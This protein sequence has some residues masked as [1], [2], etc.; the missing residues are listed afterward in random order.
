MSDESR[1]ADVRGVDVTLVC[2][3]DGNGHF[4]GRVAGAI[5]KVGERAIGLSEFS[6]LPGAAFTYVISS[7]NVGVSSFGANTSNVALSSPT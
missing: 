1:T 3:A 5:L 6:K 2:S 4:V 7:N